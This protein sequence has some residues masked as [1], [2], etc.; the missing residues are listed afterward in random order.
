MSKELPEIKTILFDLGGVL[1][2]WNPRHLFRKMFKDVDEMEYFLKEVATSD[3]NEMQDAGRPFEEAID[4]LASK[5]P[6]YQKYIQAYYYRWPEMLNGSIRET[7]EILKK[8]KEELGY[9]VYALTNWSAQT[10]PHARDQFNFLGWFEGILVSGEENMKKPDPR[11]YELTLERFGLKGENTLFIDDSLR[12]I[13]A[14]RKCGLR[15][16]QFESP[17]KL[18]ADLRLLKVI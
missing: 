8:L 4:I 18:R 3:W 16:V 10:F 9:P 11:I 1:I 5:F 15:A 6:D 13:V 17:A 14:A 12:N 2:D 7:V